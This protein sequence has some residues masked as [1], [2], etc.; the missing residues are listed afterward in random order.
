MDR[1]SFH[2]KGREPSETPKKLAFP[3]WCR[4]LLA[5]LGAALAWGGSYPRNPTNFMHWNWLHQPVYPNSV[6]PI[7]AVLILV[8]LIP[9]SWIERAIERLAR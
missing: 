5:A 1:M 7:G 4:L 8:C 9:A 6:M 3:L 2:L